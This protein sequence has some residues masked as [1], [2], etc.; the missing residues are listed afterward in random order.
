MRPPVMAPCLARDVGVTALLPD[1]YHGQPHRVADSD[2]G[3]EM[4]NEQNRAPDEEK[5]PE[6]EQRGQGKQQGKQQGQQQGQPA[7]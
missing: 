1:W 3:V 5:T 4:T 7:R 2:T 6:E